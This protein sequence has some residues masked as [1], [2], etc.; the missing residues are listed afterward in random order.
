MLGK[1]NTE[2]KDDFWL[3]LSCQISGVPVKVAKFEKP[4]IALAPLRL[5]DEEVKAEDSNS[6]PSSGSSKHQ[7]SDSESSGSVKPLTLEEQKKILNIINTSAA[8]KSES[9]DDDDVDDYLDKL[10]NESD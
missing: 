3:N 5:P 4:K 10:E 8:A 2:N 6:S 7:S 1:H 9:E